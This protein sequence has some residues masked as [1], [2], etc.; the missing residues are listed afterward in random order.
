MINS[1]TAAS[2]NQATYQTQ[3]QNHNQVQKNSQ[4]EKQPQDTVVLSKKATEG[5]Q[6]ADKD[7]DGDSH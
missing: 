5:N 1:V 6:A 2:Q 7:H 4:N 3:Q